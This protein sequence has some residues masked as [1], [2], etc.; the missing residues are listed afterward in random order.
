MKLEFVL[1]FN[2]QVNPLEGSSS[3]YTML[4]VSFLC[5]YNFESIASAHYGIFERFFWL[6]SLFGDS[7]KI[8]KF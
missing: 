7:V 2:D 6:F 3:N 1:K 5:R 4:N 8:I